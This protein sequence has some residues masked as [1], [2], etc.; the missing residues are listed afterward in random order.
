MGGIGG[1]SGGNGGLAYTRT[2]I[3][4]APT[5]V[6]EMPSELESAAGVVLLSELEALVAAAAVLMTS[7]VLTSTL[8]AS[9]DSRASS[10]PA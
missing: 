5:L 2:D 6:I 8:P 1:I 9:T 7:C 4:G 3:V 10:V